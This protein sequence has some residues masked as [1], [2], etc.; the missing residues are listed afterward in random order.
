MVLEEKK[1]MMRETSDPV[2][3]GVEETLSAAPRAIRHV[4]A[5]RTLCARRLARVGRPSRGAALARLAARR[6]VVGEPAN[7][8]VAGG[9]LDQS[10]ERNTAVRWPNAVDTAKTC[11]DSY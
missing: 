9:L 4:L 7:G 11:R 3:A 2:A 10:L 8:V 6:G 1:R 5:G